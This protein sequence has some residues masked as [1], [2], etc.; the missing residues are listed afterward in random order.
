MSFEN[1]N[2]DES[3]EQEAVA[4]R[5]GTRHEVV[6][7]SDTDIAKHFPD[8]VWRTEQPLLRTAPVPLYLLSRHVRG[9][10]FKVVLTGE[11]ADELFAGYNIFK[12]AKIRRFCAADPDSEWRAR[13]LRRLYP[14]LGELGKQPEAYLRAFFRADPADLQ[15]PLFSHRTRWKATSGIRRFLAEGFE[16]EVRGTNDEEDLLR[17]MPD[18]FPEWDVVSRAQCLES[19]LFLPGYLLSSQGDRVAMAH[20]V[21]GRFPFLDRRIVEFACKMPPQAKMP[22]LR[23]KHLL[24]SAVSDFVPREVRQRAKFPFR[25]PG[26]ECFLGR[27]DNFEYVSERLSDHALEDVGVFDSTMVRQLVRKLES[28]SNFSTRDEMAI[29][30]ILSTQILAHR[31]V[32]NFSDSRLN[33]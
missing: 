12:E 26:V 31:F 6:R 27:G 7:C 22:G 8:V 24:K 20:S 23:E 18:E 28:K 21:E 25:A 16:E 11:G 13:L 30:G 29:V 3:A 19:T 9:C 4:R 5:L 32:K 1:Q 14:Y 10:G 2:Y 17:L 15:D 33:A